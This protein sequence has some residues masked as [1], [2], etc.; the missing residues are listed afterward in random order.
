MLVFW[1]TWCG[2]CMKEI[3][4][5]RALAERHKGKPFALLGVNCD[6]DKQAAV[7]AIKSEQITWPNWHDGAPG[8][9]PIAKRYHIRGYPSVFVIDGEGIIRQTQTYMLGDVLDKAVDDLLKETKP[10]GSS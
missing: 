8:D 7:A 1:G 3:P 9:G 4:H 5:E 10:G 6:D 2:P